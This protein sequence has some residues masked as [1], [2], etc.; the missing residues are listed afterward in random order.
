MSFSK[1]FNKYKHY[2][3]EQKGTPRQWDKAFNAAFRK[4][5]GI[6]EEFYT[7]YAC[8]TEKELKKEYRRFAKIYHPDKQNGD[9]A[10]T[11]RLI[12]TYEN[13]KTQIK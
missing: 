8:T 1:L 12:E 11:Q 3:G 9:T 7:L 13:L 10:K 6:Q 2:E 5:Q 4:E